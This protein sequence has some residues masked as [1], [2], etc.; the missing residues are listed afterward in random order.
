VVMTTKGPNIIE[1]I[2]VLRSLF[3]LGLKDAK[4]LVDAVTIT[5]PVVLATH[6]SSGYAAKVIVA[7]EGVGAGIFAETMD[8]LNGA[9]DSYN[10]TWAIKGETIL[11]AKPLNTG[12]IVDLLQKQDAAAEQKPKTQPINK[13]INLRDAKALGQKVH[14]TAS[15][16]VYHVIA[17]N[18]RVK[19]ASRIYK[20][21][22]ISIRVECES[23]TPEEM[24]R[25]MKS[26]I[27][28]KGNYG[29]LHLSAGEAGEQGVRRAVGGFVFDLGSAIK[30]DQVLTYAGD[31][32]ID[33]NS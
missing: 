18:D 10:L 24:N 20:N 30:W 7:F 15:G 27:I 3:K 11:E 29:S 26:E 16:S 23:A 31:L 13:V 2:K 25:I 9:G 17:L 1:T 33:E 22:T 4:H 5:S 28:W 14:G 12:E 19:L 6:V 32:V 21:G 8:W